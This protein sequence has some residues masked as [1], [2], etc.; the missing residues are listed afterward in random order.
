MP[1]YQKQKLILKLNPALHEPIDIFQVLTK[2]TRAQPQTATTFR[3]VLSAITL[4]NIHMT[5][6]RRQRREKTIDWP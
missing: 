4:T 5:L 2:T 1:R 3:G 6:H